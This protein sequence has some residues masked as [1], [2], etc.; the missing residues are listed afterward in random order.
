VRIRSLPRTKSSR[1][2]TR[3]R[4]SG[5]S[6]E[7]TSSIVYASV[8][9]SFERRA[10]SQTCVIQAVGRFSE[11]GLSFPMNLAAEVVVMLLVPVLIDMRWRYGR[12]PILDSRSWH[13]TFKE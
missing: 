12:F 11:L 3:E 9:A 5:M 10:A 7:S 6:V 4:I 1:L 8:S 2:E 13:R